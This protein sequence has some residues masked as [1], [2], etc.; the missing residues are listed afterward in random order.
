MTLHAASNTRPVLDLSQPIGNAF[1]LIGLV[2]DYGKSL[3]WS[4]V[5]IADIKEE[6][7]SVNEYSEVVRIFERELGQF[8]D[9][10]V[11]Q[12]LEEKLL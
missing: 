8:V 12:E 10:I 5:K 11:P 2:S 4:A 9:I 7:I 3:G 1:H 6:M